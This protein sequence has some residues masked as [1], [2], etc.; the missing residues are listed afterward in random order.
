MSFILDALKKSE[1]E[2]LKNKPPKFSD[3]LMEN[4]KLESHKFLKQH[5]RN[6]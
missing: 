2:R 1:R 6:E 5:L 3:A 4:K